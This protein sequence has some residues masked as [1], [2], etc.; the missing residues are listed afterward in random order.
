MSG[1]WSCTS[2]TNDLSSSSVE[3]RSLTASRE[4]RSWLRF[5]SWSVSFLVA[6]LEAHL[7]TRVRRESDALP[8]TSA[9]EYPLRYARFRPTV[10]VP[11]LVNVGLPATGMQVL[12]HSAAAGMIRAGWS[13][14]AVQQVLGHGSAAFTLTV[15]AHLFDDDLDALA[16]ALER[17]SRGTSAVHDLVPSSAKSL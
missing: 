14:K 13:A 3:Y 6:S 10:W 17:S 12:R 16:D 11:T 9:R 2:S 7:A 1:A 8:F 5:R 4:R 15:Y